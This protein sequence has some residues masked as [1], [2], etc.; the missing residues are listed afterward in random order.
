MQAG[1]VEVQLF[2]EI[3]TGAEW[4]K[5]GLGGVKRLNHTEAGDNRCRGEEA[6]LVERCCCAPANFDIWNID[7]IIKK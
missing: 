5:S 1:S 2:F 4:C 3:R 6:S 7:N